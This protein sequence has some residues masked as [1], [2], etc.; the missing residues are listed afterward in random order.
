MTFIDFVK[1]VTSSSRILPYG[2]FIRS[3]DLTPVNKYGIDMRAHRLMRC[4]PNIV[5][6]TL[7]HPTTLKSETIREIAKYNTKLHTLSMGGIESF[8]FM[9]ECNFSQLHQLQHVTLTTTP[10][11]ASSFMT[12]PAKKLKSMRLV[13]MDAVTPQEL[14]AFCQSHPKLQSLSIVN[15]RALN[16]PELGH[17]LAK[18][19]TMHDPLANHELHTIELVGPQMTD[20]N[21]NPLFQNVPKGSRLKHLKLQDTHITKALMVFCP[22]Q[23]LQI[24]NLELVNNHNLQV[25]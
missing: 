8:P 3:I 20:E 11:L 4:C 18:V 5:Q 19:L 6:M 22:H 10:L 14:L 23:Y 1:T 25:G 16:S 13:Q 12:L 24:E 17:V 21:L 15:C 2:L 9:L 7:G